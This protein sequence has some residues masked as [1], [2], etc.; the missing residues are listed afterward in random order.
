[1]RTTSQLAINGLNAGANQTS[2]WISCDMINRASSVITV[3]G[4]TSI[5][6]TV[7]LQ[8]S[9]QAPISEGLQFQTAG[10]PTR[11]VVL[12][13]AKI[14]GNGSVLIPSVDISYRWIRLAYNYVSGSGGTVTAD[15]AIQGW[16]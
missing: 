7:D 12:S 1:M 10:L 15:L 2:A 16:L 5:V 9:D 3:T 11:F 14:S 8:V 6:A 4:G 13:S